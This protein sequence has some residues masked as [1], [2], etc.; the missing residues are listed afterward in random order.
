[1]CVFYIAWSC[2]VYGC[3]PFLGRVDRIKML[4]NSTEI[5]I[6]F[7][8]VLSCEVI[9]S[10][11]MLQRIPKYVPMFKMDPFHL[12]IS[13]ISPLN[14]SASPTNLNGFGVC[15]NL[16][17]RFCCDSRYVR[18]TWLIDSSDSESKQSRFHQWRHNVDTRCRGQRVHRLP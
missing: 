11:W 2:Y 17:I 12:I 1:M 10:I 13:A 8:L 18:K 6:L 4:Q 9:T 14:T 16:L 3:P 15:F 5:S 7:N